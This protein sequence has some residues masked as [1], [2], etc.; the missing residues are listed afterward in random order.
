MSQQSDQFKKL[1]SHC[2]EYGFIYQ[3]SEVY[4]GL[5][6]VYDYG[7]YGVELKNNI[8]EYWW[9]AMVQMHENI[10]GIDAAIFMHPKT[11]KASGHVDAFNDPLIDNLDSKKRY[12]ADVLIEEHI[13]KIEAKITKEVTK[14]AKRFGDS[15]DEQQYRSTNGRVMGY[16]E[17][18]DTITKRLAQA[19]TDGNL[20]ELKNL[21][22]ELEIADDTGSRNW[23]DVRQF[24][25]MFSTQL[26]NIAGEE[27]KLYLRPE[28]AQGIFVNFLN[29]QKTTRQKLPF[30]IAQI[31]KAFRNEIT[32]RQFIFRM[33]EF[34]QMEMQF[35]IPPGSQADWYKYWKEARMK[36]HLALGTPQSKL[37]F[38]D[39]DNL[40]HYADAAVD[41]QFEFPFGFKELEGI[42]SRTDF[43][44]GSHQ[45]LSGKKLQYFDP[46]SKESYVP[47]VL[48][49]SIGCDRMFLATM[50]NALVEEQVPGQDDPNNTREVLK[51]HPALAPVKCAVF[52]LKRN[53]ERLVSKAKEIFNQLK[54][55]FPTQ[56]D[57]I[58]SIGKLYRRQDA[59][60]T[61][62][63]ITVD[64]ESLDDNTVTIRE[65]DSLTQERVPIE[66]V[67]QIVKE[68]I[69]MVQLFRD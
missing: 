57:D 19:M 62:Y 55:S 50:S 9:K 68:R 6:A 22:V 23:T 66:R 56:Y 45:E 60:G 21:I 16:Q 12:R 65:R 54:F 43:D 32:A 40:A 39:H 34:E 31:G 44:L 42:H 58:G 37:R 67:E 49:T 3:S 41:I 2:K 47:Y 8:K 63:C 4:D 1:V 10:V 11:W 30:G 53:D 27:G 24:N 20:E 25:L 48:E 69:D 59:I 35:F 5:A 61:P 46:E 29:V 18:I 28:T 15:F 51:L 17:Q 13:D 14:A 33:R 38:H 26:G 52:P 64:F 7:P 36:W